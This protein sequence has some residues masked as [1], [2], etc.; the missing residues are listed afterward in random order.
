MGIREAEDFMRWLQEYTEEL[1][2]NDHNDL[3]NNDGVITT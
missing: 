1:Y 2:E 3:D